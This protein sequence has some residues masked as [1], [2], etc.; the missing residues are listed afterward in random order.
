MWSIPRKEFKIQNPA[1]FFNDCDDKPK[2]KK[3]KFTKEKIIKAIMKLKSSG[4]SG[5]DGIT[6]LLMKIFSEELS[7]PLLT[8]YEN[9]MNTGVF[10][11][12]WKLA[13]ICPVKKPGKSIS[14]A[15]SFR[16]V[17]LTSQ[18]GKVM[19]SIINNEMRIFLEDDNLIN[20]AEHEFRSCKSNIFQLLSHYEK[21]IRALENGSN[22]DI[23]YLDF[24]KAFDKADIG[25]VLHRCREKGITGDLGIWI[26]DYLSNRRQ[27]VIS[28]NEISEICEVISTVPQGSILGPLFFFI[29]IDNIDENITKLSA[30]IFADDTK[31][32]SEIKTIED[33]ISLQNDLTVLY[34][35]SEVNNMAFNGLKLSVSNMVK[36]NC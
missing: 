13:H 9:S 25:L 21:I 30:S 26:L 36:M 20:P 15:E 28:N 2:I 27:A 16:P 34:E 24:Q 17:A 8:I 35:W 1:S 12:I 19:E 5:P 10:P 31:A 14:K 33:A 3:I 7:T 22:F 11:E 32:T 4:S 29:L 18:M 6:P 23:I